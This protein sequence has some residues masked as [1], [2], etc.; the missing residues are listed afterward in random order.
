MMPNNLKGRYWAFVLYPESAPNDWKDIL[1]LSGLPCAISPLHDKDLN[2]DL[3]K[4]KSHYHIIL[5]WDGPT[6]YKNVCSLVCDQLHQPHP[7][8]IEVV[9]GYY[10]YLTHKDNPEKAQYNDFDI[11]VLNGFNP[12]DYD[13]PTEREL[14]IICKEIQKL[15][16]TEHFTEYSELMDFLMLN[17]WFQHY[18]FARRNTV[19]L[20]AYIDS[21]RYKTHQEAI[22]C[23]KDRES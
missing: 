1:S 6:T 4:K 8:K 13:Q 12:E 16:L 14:D 20:K 15:I 11:T 21:R 18:R 3:E 23:N 19:F 22:S 5:C 17:D 7:I 2:A 10:R 9:R